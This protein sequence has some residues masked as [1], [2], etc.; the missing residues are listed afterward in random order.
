[1]TTPSFTC[2]YFGYDVKIGIVQRLIHDNIED[3][4]T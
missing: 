4:A 3:K 1:M 2:L